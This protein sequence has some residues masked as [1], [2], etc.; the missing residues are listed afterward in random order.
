MN[1]YGG[2]GEDCGAVWVV[3]IVNVGAC[4]DF[5]PHDEKYEGRRL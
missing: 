1:G 3:R 5:D 4:C 2:D